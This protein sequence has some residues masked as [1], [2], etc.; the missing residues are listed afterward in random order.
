MGYE[1]NM[2]HFSASSLNGFNECA[3]KFFIVYICKIKAKPNK[4]FAKGNAIHK[5]AEIAIQRYNTDKTKLSF[6]DVRPIVDNELSQY[7]QDIIDQLDKIQ[8]YNE[9][10]AV[11]NSKVL[12]RCHKSEVQ[13]AIYIPY[14]GYDI[15]V[16]DSWNASP[17]DNEDYFKIIG[18]IDALSFNDAEKTVIDWKTGQVKDIEDLKKDFQSMVYGLYNLASFKS[19]KYRVTFIYVSNRLKERTIQFTHKDELFKQLVDKI[20]N[21][22]INILSCQSFQPKKSYLCRFCDFAPICE[23]VQQA[24]QND[25]PIEIIT[26]YI[27]ENI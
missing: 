6:E 27:K 2:K 15:Q 20:R 14:F 23:D 19:E 8:I 7:S 4:Y 9:A 21:Q 10:L 11:A 25:I 1:I 13:F 3:L 12:E 16:Y 26:D 18:R 5:V 22:C 24:I 17:M